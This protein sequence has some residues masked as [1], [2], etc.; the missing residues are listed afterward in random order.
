SHLSLSAMSPA[1]PKPTV[2]IHTNDRQLVAALVGAHSLRSRSMSPDLFNIRLLRLEETPH[3]YRR[4]KQRFDWWDGDGPSVFRRR[5]LQ[6]FA[7]LR[8]MVPALMNFQG[9]ALVLDP[10]VFAI[11]DVY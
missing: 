8:R 10:D 1:D 9:R 5:D 4:N 11:G 2:I 3:L 6:A 7:P